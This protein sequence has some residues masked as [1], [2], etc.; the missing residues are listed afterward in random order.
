MRRSN[1]KLA[2]AEWPWNFGETP[3]GPITLYFSTAGLTALEF[4]TAA[5]KTG[6]F[7]PSLPSAI[8][9]LA[10]AARLELNRY[11]AGD[12]TAFSAL[13]LDLHGTP[14]QLRVWEELRR[15]PWG[16]T[17]SYRELARRV[18]HLR[19]L[20]AVGQANALNPVPLIIPC[21]RV[22]SADG[23]LGGYRAGLE[24]KRWLLAHERAL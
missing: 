22:I 24:R 21:H 9:P 16:A 15:I 11:F 5:Q 20:R 8:Q 18:G 1:A 10:E 4:A 3:V 19:A 12:P 17:I 2:A 14:F 6:A 23:G 13:T 7:P